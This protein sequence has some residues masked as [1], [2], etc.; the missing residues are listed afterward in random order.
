ME[1]YRPTTL[2]QIVGQK[3]IIDILKLFVVS[4]QIP[5]MMF[6]G[7]PGVGKTATAVALAKELFGNDYHQC[8]REINASDE[9]GIK[10]VREKIKNI[11][12]MA[13]YKRD[14][15]IIFLDEADEL[16]N[17]A[18]A[19]LRRTIETASSTCRF[20]FSCNYPNKIIEPIADRLY[21][22]RFKHL[23]TLDMKFL[24]EKIVKEEQISITNEA[25]T[26]L[27]SLSLGSMRKALKIL[28]VIKMANLDKVN[29]EKIYELVNWI[30][31]EFIEKL[32]RATVSGDFETVNK[33]I[34]NLLYDKMYEPREIIQQLHLVVRESAILTEEA[35]ILALKE[36]GT[37]EYRLSVG[38]NA[39]IQLRTLMSYLILVFKKYLWQ[40]KEIIKNE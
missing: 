33:R 40:K 17:D 38:C 19:A 27:G 25:L 29:E 11:A 18:Q 36:I 6:S 10:V 1:K 22:C 30:N 2:N 32:V 7:P 16:T 21:E 26:T 23:K 12:N 4:G 34:T 13:S 15:K 35:K 24:L 8:F 39:E 3:E 5:H 20:I 14:Y 9:R 31:S 28:T 37:T